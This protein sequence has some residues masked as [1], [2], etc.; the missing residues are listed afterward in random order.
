[1][2]LFS[3]T[4]EPEPVQQDVAPRRSS[5]MNSRT[6]SR[7][8]RRH[9]SIFS[10][11]RDRDS[12]PDSIGTNRTGSTRASGSGFFNRG[13]GNEDPS[14]SGARQRVIDA[15]VAERDA[16]RALMAAK[17]AVKDARDHVKSLELEA[18]EQARLAKLKQRAAGDISKRARPL[19]KHDRIL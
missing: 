4:K 11:H 19:G 6:S 3:T 14:I 13:H 1:M 10:R 5:T 17:S 2:G 15:E 7:S 8:P 18:K 12:S 9:G 16:D